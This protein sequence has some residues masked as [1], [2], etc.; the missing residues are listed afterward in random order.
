MATTEDFKRM[1]SPESILLSMR[2]L[3]S[4]RNKPQRPRAKKPKVAVFYIKNDEKISFVSISAAAN[5]TIDV[6]SRSRRS[7]HI[8]ESIELKKPDYQ[9]I[10]WFKS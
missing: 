5:A 4:V 8:Q 3:F 1:F 6:Y 7:V 9:G 2:T 10:Q